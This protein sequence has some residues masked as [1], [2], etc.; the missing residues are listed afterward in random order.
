MFFLANSCSGCN[1][2]ICTA[3]GEWRCETIFDCSVDDGMT[4]ADRETVSTALDILYS[5][6]VLIMYNTLDYTVV[7]P[8]FQHTTI[9]LGVIE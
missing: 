7:S 2:C 3:E 8:R 9:Y 5:G 1:R 6:I 4:P